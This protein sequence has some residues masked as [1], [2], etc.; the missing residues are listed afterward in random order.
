MAAPVPVA[1]A[2]LVDRVSGPELL[3]ALLLTS[4]SPSLD[5]FLYSC[6]ACGIH[7]PWLGIPFPPAG[8]RVLPHV[9]IAQQPAPTTGHTEIMSFLHACATGE[10]AQLA[11]QS[12]PKGAT[13]AELAPLPSRIVSSSPTAAASS[14]VRAASPP[15]PPSAVVAVANARLAHAPATTSD[16][17]VVVLRSAERVPVKVRI[18]DDGGVCRT[19]K[20]QCTHPIFCLACGSR[21]N[22]IKV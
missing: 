19:C 11:V 6:A 8:V 16:Q 20:V 10:I 18:E 14:P 15:P 5:D 1:V 17:V 4:T 3:P 22:V 2:A 9:L 7:E 21:R 12:A 13:I